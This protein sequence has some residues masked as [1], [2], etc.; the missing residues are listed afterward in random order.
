MKIGLTGQI[1]AGKSSAAEILR[2]FGAH[3]IN[4]DEIGR[5][6]VEKSI[7]VRRKLVEAFGRT[8]LDKQGKLRRAQLAKLA[9]ASEEA[10]EQLNAIVHPHLLKKL[11]AEVA[12]GARTGKVIVIDAALLVAWG[13]EKEV[14]VV[15]LMN[16][17]EKLRLKR[18]V[19]RGISLEDARA[20]QA[21]QPSIDR[22]RQVANVVIDNSATS[23]ELA[24]K[25]VQFW[26]RYVIPGM[27]KSTGKKA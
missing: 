23:V 13:L 27:S 20:R 15:V 24:G 11:R 19:A 7:P 18:T 26:S 21:A 16:A 10:T 17:P 22:M 25:L 1:G 8:I 6:V 5:M 2:S 14:D 4:A 12:K 3:I 9:F